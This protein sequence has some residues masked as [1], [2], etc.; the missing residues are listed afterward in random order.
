VTWQQAGAE[1]F[2]NLKKITGKKTC[3]QRIAI[4]TISMETFKKK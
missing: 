4:P 2:E 3:K 1:N